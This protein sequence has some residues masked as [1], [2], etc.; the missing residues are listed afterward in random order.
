MENYNEKLDRLEKK[1]D[2]LCSNIINPISY[3]FEGLQKAVTKCM[4]MFGENISLHQTI[5]EL[6]ILRRM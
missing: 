4:D 2:Y 5:T 1:V 3:D 6:D